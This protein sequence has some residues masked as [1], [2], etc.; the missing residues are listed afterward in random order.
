MSFSNLHT[1]KRTQARSRCMWKIQ[2]GLG[3]GILI[4]LVGHLQAQDPLKMLPNNYKLAFENP[5]VAVISAH[6]AP[7][8]KLGVHDHSMVPTIYV[9]LSDSGPVRFSHYKEN[10]SPYIAIRPPIKKGAFRISSGQIERHSVENLGDISSDFL[11]VELKQIPLG[12]SSDS[13]RGQAP[14]DLS[15]SSDQIEF[16]NADLTVERIVCVSGASCPISA[17]ATP[18]LIIG[19]APAGFKGLQEEIRPISVG[20]TVWIRP[21]ESGM[22][23]STSCCPAHLLRIFLPPNKS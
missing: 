11:R 21:S 9:Y 8:E 15:K 7:H 10:E 5:Q 18:S 23:K 17:S 1:A 2:S 3:L 19:L 20:S 4:A 13:F 16:Q 14:L 12:H 6:Y 22:I